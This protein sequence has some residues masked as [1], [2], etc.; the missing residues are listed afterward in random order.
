M[1]RR[2]NPQ[3][4]GKLFWIFMEMT[5]M[6]IKTLVSIRGR[7]ARLEFLKKYLT[8]IGIGLGVMIIGGLIAG[9][10]IKMTT[11]LPDPIFSYVAFALVV[12]VFLIGIPIVLFLGVIQWSQIVRRLHDLDSSGWYFVFMFVP[13]L[14]LVLFCL[15]FF[16]KGTRGENKYGLDPLGFNEDPMRKSVVYSVETKA[17]D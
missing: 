14:N 8:V 9:Y 15:L 13:I 7:L 12:A 5:G 10:G 4:D 11:I 1:V 17:S 2:D 3:E 6:K 16:A